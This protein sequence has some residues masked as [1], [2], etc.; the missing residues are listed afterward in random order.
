MTAGTVHDAAVTV[1]IPTRDRPVWVRR[2]VALACAQRDIDVR[3]V[4]VDDHSADGDA[5]A[6][7]VSQD[8]R[9]TL[10]R[11]GPGERGVAAARNVGLASVTTPYVAFLDDD[12]VWD[13]AW[14]AT[15]VSALRDAGAV[16][17]FGPVVL[18]DGGGRPRGW[19]PSGD[20]SQAARKLMHD[21]VV[22]GPS[23]VVVTTEAV[24][25][26]G[27]WDTRFSALADWELW[28]RLR[29]APFAAVDDILVGYSL[30]PDAMHLRDPAAM[31]AEF[32]LLRDVT[33]HEELDE[34]RFSRWLAGECARFG[35]R[36]DAARLYCELA[37]DER[38]PLD[39]ARAA[40]LL[41][42]FRRPAR[43]VPSTS[44]DWW[45]A[46]ERLSA[47]ARGPVTAA[48]LSRA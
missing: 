11:A 9:V 4:V 33:G 47:L 39:L 28:L 22:G 25:A 45:P 21:N 29:D 35:A 2:A 23:Q 13:P 19:E 18:L 24:R 10:L 12:D 48:E 46:A 5:V 16:L 42:P 34:Q 32:R 20:P 30:H 14:L 31:L 17:V 40:R 38:R 6:R 43:H 27:G 37:V 1:V 3:V 41:R 15:A 26:A 8:P 44:K 7:A 36:R